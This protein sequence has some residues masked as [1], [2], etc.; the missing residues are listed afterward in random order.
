MA[1]SRNYTVAFKRKRKGKTD[2]RK[3]MMYLKSGKARLVVRPS[4]NNLQM[5]VVSFND[6]GDK[7]LL[8]INSQEIKKLGWRYHTGNIP[9]SYLT[10]LLIGKKSGV[11]DVIVD[12]GLS[13]P[14]K[15]SRLY[16][17]IKGVRDAGLNIPCSD[18]VFPSEETIKGKT[19]QIFASNLS[20]D[21]KKKQ[22]SKLDPK[23]M[24]DNF[25]EVKKKIMEL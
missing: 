10:G 23:D 7:V 8:S 21:D 11:K 24:V 9:S 3:R 20:E 5:Q 18:E 22:F 25:D 12:F 13:S 14:I 4:Q 19:I 15:G 17:A 16:A 6:S 1:K 2:Y